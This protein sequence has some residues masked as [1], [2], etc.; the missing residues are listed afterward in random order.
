M[1]LLGVIQSEMMK[2]FLAFLIFAELNF[3]YI[4]IVIFIS[5]QHVKNQIFVLR[6]IFIKYSSHGLKNILNSSLNIFC[7]TCFG[8]KNLAQRKDRI[9]I[10]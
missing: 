6:E 4:H 5:I 10:V 9:P 1:F 8:D 7:A 2:Q 3:F